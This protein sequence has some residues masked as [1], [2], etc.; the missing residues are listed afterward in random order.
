MKTRITLKD[1]SALSPVA[2]QV[3]HTTARAIPESSAQPTFESVWGFHV[4]PDR[5]DESFRE[6]HRRY[7]A[8]FTC[9]SL[10]QRGGLNE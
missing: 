7:I 9:E 8:P 1:F 10:Y 6:M 2:V 5:S 4:P 3:T